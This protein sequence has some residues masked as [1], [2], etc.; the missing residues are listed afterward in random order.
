MLALSPIG[1]AMARERHI[2]FDLAA[3]PLGSALVEF[4]NRTGMTALIDGELANGLHSPPV[5]GR[6]SPTDALQVL[7]AGTGLAIRYVGANAFTVGPPPPN[8][9]VG[10]PGSQSTHRSDESAYFAELQNSV[11]RALCR[12]DDTRLGTYRAAFQ[13]WIEESGRIRALH[14]LGSTGNESLDAAITTR[15]TS[16]TVVPPPRDLPQ[17]ITIIL[18]AA[19]SNGGCSRSAGAR[20]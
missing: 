5:K 16:D 12:N 13:V 7:L 15:I 18:R 4:A 2:N 9:T 20:L 17:P 8:P 19:S 1:G 3:Q 6:F 11:E 10:I 14:L